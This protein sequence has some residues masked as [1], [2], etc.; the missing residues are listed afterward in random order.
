[1]RTLLAF[2]FVA[3][4]YAPT[5]PEGIACGDDTAC[6][7]SL[8]CSMGK[9]VSSPL[10][11]PLPPACIPIEEGVGALVIPKLEAAPTVDGDLSDWP[12]CF[13]SVDQS[14]AGLVRDLGAGG[15]F[16]PGRFS[17]GANGDRLYVVA[18]VQSVLPL[19]DHAVPDVYLN[20]AISVYFDGD[21]EFLTNAYGDDAAQIVI[22]HANRTASF[23][24]DNGGIIEIPEQL[25][26]ARVGASTFTIEMS[27]TPASLGLD[28]FAST[29]G[30][31]I[32]LVG[33]DGE[34]MTS[35][36]VWFQACGDPECVCSA[37]HSDSAPY[38][39]SRQFGTARFLE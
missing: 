31:D 26:A 36:L 2:V 6:P 16:A 18:E 28:A 35:E 9:C 7:S 10:D 8:M 12:T 23:Q 15:K 5:P 11:A 32:G 34:V 39:D 1:M 22:D 29:I 17:I 3:G 27:I 25:N 37:G 24:A 20:N 38:C 21:G 33:G 19:G 4:C 14:N 13:V 30:F